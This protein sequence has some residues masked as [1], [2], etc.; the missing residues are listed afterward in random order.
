MKKLRIVGGTI[1]AVLLTAYLVFFATSPSPG[2]GFA[3]DLEGLRRTAGTDELPTD[4]RVLHIADGSMPAFA[5]VAGAGP[6]SLDA[7]YT[8]F[9]IVSPDGSFVIVDTAYEVVG[10]SSAA[11]KSWST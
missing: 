9:Q 7:V 4:V 10:S 5:A 3:I 6:T 11:R 8:S 2:D 1:V